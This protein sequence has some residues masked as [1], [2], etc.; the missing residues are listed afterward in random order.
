[1]LRLACNAHRLRLLDP[2]LSDRLYRVFETA[3]V[4]IPEHFDDLFG[5]LLRYFPTDL[6]PN[7][8]NILTDLRPVGLNTR[9][10]RPNSPVPWTTPRRSSLVKS[11]SIDKAIEATLLS[12]PTLLSLELQSPASLVI[13]RG[14]MLARPVDSPHSRMLSRRLGIPAHLQMYVGFMD[15]LGAESPSMHMTSFSQSPTDWTEEKKELTTSPLII[16]GGTDMMVS[17][18]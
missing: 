5:S 14:R 18:P 17:P 9:T 6:H 12:L 10:L 1:M 4:V 2:D 11:D 13:T 8:S 3:A 7:L 15:P 16:N